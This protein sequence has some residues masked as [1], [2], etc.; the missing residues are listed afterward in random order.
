[1]DI[2]NFPLNEGSRI[3]IY[4]KSGAGKTYLM[5]EQLMMHLPRVKQFDYILVASKTLMFQDKFKELLTGV[6]IDEYY[7]SMDQ[8]LLNEMIEFIKNASITGKHT[9]LIMDDM[10]ADYEVNRRTRASP[11]TDL[12]VNARHYKVHIILLLQDMM[13][14]NNAIRT[15]ADT[16][17]QFNPYYNEKMLEQFWNTYLYDIPKTEFQALIDDVFSKHTSTERREYMVLKRIGTVY[18]AFSQIDGKWMRLK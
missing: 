14:V 13:M 5:V 16:I 11:M 10:G 15:S 4:G 6:E 9:L 2:F 3:I 1:M 7:D 17:I 12:F 18:E 8:S